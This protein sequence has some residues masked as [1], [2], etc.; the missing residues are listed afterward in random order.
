MTFDVSSRQNATKVVHGTT[1][2]LTGVV[3]PARAGAV[4]L[5]NY[6]GGAWHVSATGT[7]NVNSAHAFAVTLK[8]AATYSFR[9]VKAG[10]TLLGTGVSPTF[11]VTAT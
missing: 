10:D 2:T 11:T 7:L 4:L 8:S 6:Y 5:E 9:F 1:V 3:L